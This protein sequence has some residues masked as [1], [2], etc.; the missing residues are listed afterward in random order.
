MKTNPNGAICY[1]NSQEQYFSYKQSNTNSLAG[2]FV[3]GLQQ[4][5]NVIAVKVLQQVSTLPSQES[6]GPAIPEVGQGGWMGELFSEIND[7]LEEKKHKYCSMKNSSSSLWAVEVEQKFENILKSKDTKLI[8]ELISEYGLEEVKKVV[9][10]AAFV[11]L[12]AEEGNLELVK[13]LVVDMKC[14]P[15][16]RHK[17]DSPLIGAVGK[18]NIEV[19][20]FLLDVSAPESFRDASSFKAGLITHAEF[21][22]QPAEVITFLIE[23]RDR[24]PISI[25]GCAS[26]AVYLITQNRAKVVD[27]L[28]SE[29][30]SP[31]KKDTPIVDLA[32]MVVDLA[33]SNNSQ[34]L[35]SAVENDDPILVDILVAA[36]ALTDLK[37]EKGQTPLE[38][39]KHPLIERRLK[40]TQQMQESFRKRQVEHLTKKSDATTMDPS[41]EIFSW[42]H[43]IA[44]IGSTPN[45]Q[46]ELLEVGDRLKKS[47]VMR[48]IGRNTYLP[49]DY[50]V[51]FFQKELNSMK[52]GE[53][54][55]L[56]DPPHAGHHTVTLVE[57]QKDGKFKCIQGD[58]YRNGG[59]YRQIA[60]SR[61]ITSDMRKLTEHFLGTE[62]IIYGYNPFAYSYPHLGGGNS[63]QP[64]YVKKD[65]IIL[66]KWQGAEN[67]CVTQSDTVIFDYI[68]AEKLNISKFDV[69]RQIK[70]LRLH[71]LSSLLPKEDQDSAE[72]WFTGSKED[73]LRDLCPLILTSAATKGTSPK[74]L[75]Q[76]LDQF[77]TF[78]KEKGV[79]SLWNKGND[80]PIKTVP[81]QQWK[82]LVK[83]IP[84]KTS[85]PTRR[86]YINKIRRLTGPGTHLSFSFDGKS[87]GTFTCD[88]FDPNISVQCYI[89]PTGKFAFKDENGNF[90]KG[91]KDFDA[92]WSALS[93]IFVEAA[94]KSRSQPNPEIVKSWV[95][96]V[97]KTAYKIAYRNHYAKK[98]SQGQERPPMGDDWVDME[99][100]IIQILQRQWDQKEGEV[101]KKLLGFVAQ[102][103]SESVRYRESIRELTMKAINLIASKAVPVTEESGVLWF[104]RYTETVSLRQV[105]ISL[106]FI[107]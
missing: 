97:I 10:H 49:K 102:P 103:L 13:F 42:S 98:G 101:I 91:Y 76:Q 22:D 67:N 62:N 6:K 80:A 57:K 15:N 24:Y 39:A 69:Y 46:P 70:P 82:T 45:P 53:W 44:M 74:D 41:D 47:L 25:S 19:V 68:L 59:K 21:N 38:I 52:P 95:K 90:T 66:K 58:R 7:Q 71:F 1:Q 23:L 94:L 51:H 12:A 34:A 61:V 29:L 28:S 79:L 107:V 17:N 26:T 99:Q 3:T 87:T 104:K 81:W 78:D 96:D 60:D 14:D 27:W 92:L 43:L 30:R 77:V 56:N 72:V 105:E 37:N 8:Q 35:F 33:N 31:L 11:H 86:L 4:K 93:E 88:L 18:G 36:G 54:I 50:K 85:D 73:R 9:D 32:A 89:S 48:F 83:G 16:V 64:E 63:H 2:R 75:L 55:I 20:K 65:G 106:D 100:Q 84:R 40:E 5:Q